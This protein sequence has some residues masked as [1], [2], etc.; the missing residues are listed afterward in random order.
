M[1]AAAGALIG[2]VAGAGL[3]MVALGL[4]AGRSSLDRLTSIAAGAGPSERAPGPAANLERL[5]RWV[6]GPAAADRQARRRADLAVLELPADRWHAQRLLLA[7]TGTV[8]PVAGVVVSAGLAPVVGPGPVLGPSVSA[9]AAVAGGAA[10]WFGAEWWLGKRAAGA[11]TVLR[12]AVAVYLDLAAV[13]VAGGAGPAEAMRTAAE[14]GHGAP[15]LRIRAAIAGAEVTQRSAYEAL[16]ALGRRIGLAELRDVGAAMAL[17][18]RQGAPVAAT[19][20]GKAAAVAVRLL[21]SEQAAAETRS[22]AMSLP[23]VLMLSGFLLF[24]MYPFVAALVATTG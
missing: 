18:E 24:L 13:A 5:E 2:A 20:G 21:A 8:G 3:L 11:R 9:L 15:F 1:S 7:M 23:S 16:E 22:V 12:S 4:S 19:L 14:A 10:G 17:A 6:L